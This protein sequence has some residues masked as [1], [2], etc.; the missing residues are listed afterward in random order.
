MAVEDKELVGTFYITLYIEIE[1]FYLYEALLIR[2]LTIIYK[3]DNPV[4]QQAAFGGL[5]VKV[6]LTYKDDIQQN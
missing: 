5:G 1:V 3:V 6:D 2:C 4:Q